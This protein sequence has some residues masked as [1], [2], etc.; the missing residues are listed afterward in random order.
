MVLGVGFLLI[1]SLL[2]STLVQSLVHNFGQVIGSIM[3]RPVDGLSNQSVWYWELINFGVSFSITAILFA[4]IFKVLPNADVKW[5]N[6]WPGGILTAALFVLGKTVLALY[7][8]RSGL[9]TAFGAA[10]SVIL[11]LVWV[12]YTAQI[13]FFCAEFTYAYSKRGEPAAVVPAPV[14]SA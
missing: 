7:L 4:S 2:V 12:Y 13:F 9:T 6:V 11:I 14:T 5:R 10:G 8:G 1:V 3:G